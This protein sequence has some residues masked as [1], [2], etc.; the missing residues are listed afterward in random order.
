[1]KRK[2]ITVRER[3]ERREGFLLIAPACLHISIFV[4]IPIFFAFILSFQDWNMLSPEK[5]FVGFENYRQMV[6]DS[7]FYLSLKNTFW[8]TVGSVPVCLVC[9]LLLAVAMKKKS[10]VNGFLRTCFFLPVI[11][12]LVVT[13]VVFMW[14]FDPMIG[15]VNY[16]LSKL[17]IGSLVWLSDPELALPT[18]MIVSVWKSLGY[19]MVIF[20]AG[21]QAIPDVYYEASRIDGASGV[22][23]F[24]KIT[25]PLLKPTTLFVLIMSVISSFQVFDQV[26]LMT[27]G[28]PVNSTKVIV[29]YIYETAFY[30]FDMGYASALSFVLFILI[31][32]LTLIQF[33]VFSIN[34]DEM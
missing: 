3:R 34:D 4:I 23:Q 7:V 13:S 14:M 26:Y 2:N 17:G 29:F 30:Y 9:S 33:K 32:L 6:T 8:Y 25:I 18:L 31:L 24:F 15:L 11:V 22:Q 28:G 21:I 5:T 27:S 10:A 12:S 1:M 16:Y 20:L 19:N